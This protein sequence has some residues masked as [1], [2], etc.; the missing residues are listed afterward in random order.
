MRSRKRR[1]GYEEWR[2]AIKRLNAQP[3]AGDFN[4]LSIA[5]KVHYI[6]SEKENV[7]PK[8]IRDAA[9]QYDWENIT[10]SDIDEVIKFLKE[11][12]A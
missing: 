7:T 5:A 6:T 2:E 4:K 10:N 1:E 12:F 8:Q 3:L 11:F 9:K